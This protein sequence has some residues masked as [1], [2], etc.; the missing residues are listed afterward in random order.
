MVR[1][2]MR[3]DTEAAVEL[4]GQLWP[5]RRIDP[6]TAVEII[7]RYV[8]DPNYWMYGYEDEGAL[9]GMVTVSF[10]WTLFH[11]GEVA[12]IEDLVVAQAH[13]GKGIGGA[14]VSFAER[15]ALENRRA[16]AFE[17]SSDLHGEDAHVF[18]QKC[19]HSPPAVQFGKRIA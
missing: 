7:E 11:L 15:K 4:L 2:L 13:R 19:G 14:L 1:E 9:R 5:G 8:Y 12:I 6:A 16:A 3:A 17:V 18:C 10:R